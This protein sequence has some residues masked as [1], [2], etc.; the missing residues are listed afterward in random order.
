MMRNSIFITVL[1]SILISTG[2]S[3][4]QGKPEPVNK[5]YKTLSLLR[6]EP[7]GKRAYLDTIAFPWNEY[8]R[9]AITNSLL[10]TIYLSTA[11]EAKLPSLISYPANSSEQ[12]RAELDYLRKLQLSRTAEEIK[13]AEYIAMIGSSPS[14]VN[15]LDSEY[16]INKNQLFYIAQHVGDWY[17]PD[18]FPTTARLLMNAIQDIR[19]TEFR[20]KRFFK[21]ARPYHLEPKLQPLARIGSPSFASGHTLWA[22][23]QAYLFSEMLPEK[24]SEFIGRA[25]EVRWSRE[26][27]GI[28][29]PSDNEASR[30]IAWQLLQYWKTNPQFVY[31]LEQAKIEWQ[32]KRNNFK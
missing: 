18:N 16:T 15:P 25:E 6:S 21:R 23:T 31:D 7:D 28:H 8:S 4:P 1:L 26:L 10:R 14:I 20:L 2:W 30:L 3:Q 17:N 22:F 5:H 29:Y 9:G 24:R 11:D 32:L 19:A 12:T 13:R 27:M